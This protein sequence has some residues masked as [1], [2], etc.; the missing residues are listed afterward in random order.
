M[1]EKEKQSYTKYLCS[2]ENYCAIQCRGMQSRS[3]CLPH[4][5]WTQSQEW[6]QEFKVPD[7][8]TKGKTQK[9]L[10]LCLLVSVFVLLKGTY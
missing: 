2:I 8:S 5:S 7:G 6:Y 4:M 10:R 3:L 9:I 1:S